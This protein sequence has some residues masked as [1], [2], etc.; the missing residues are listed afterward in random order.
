MERRCVEDDIGL[1][2]ADDLGGPIDVH[3]VDGDR[4]DRGRRAEVEG[5]VAR[6]IDPIV[7]L[8]G[9][10]GPGEDLIAGATLAEE[11]KDRAAQNAAADDEYPGL[12][13]F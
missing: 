2:G 6:Q 9:F 10:S 1:Q 5:R 13:L 12:R 3:E 7:D 4:L 11:I 8:L